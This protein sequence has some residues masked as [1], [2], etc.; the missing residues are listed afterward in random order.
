MKKFSLPPRRCQ[1]RKTRYPFIITPNAGDEK[2]N[3]YSFLAILV[4]HTV[5]E[6][7]S[8]DILAF[9]E[10]ARSYFSDDPVS[11]RGATSRR[12]TLRIARIVPRCV[13]F[14]SFSFRR[15][16]SVSERRIIFLP[17]RLDRGALTLVSSTISARSSTVD[18]F[19]SPLAA[20][21]CSAF[22]S[23]TPAWHLNIE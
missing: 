2:Q 4:R 11:P 21:S 10:P 8:I 13:A 17:W 9:V 14:C 12:S 19:C 15:D 20:L 5:C 18:D 1:Q 16:P 23:G 22:S 6:S 3:D 7:P